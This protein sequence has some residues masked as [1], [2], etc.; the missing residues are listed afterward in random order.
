MA[1]AE[2]LL[3]R[4]LQT[5]PPSW[6]ILPPL[7]LTARFRHS[8]YVAARRLIDIALASI[9][10]ALSLPVLAAAAA[11]V[12]LT[13]RGPLFFKQLRAGK[14]G[15]PFWMYK[16]RSM[17]AGADDD[18]HLFANLNELQSSPCFKIR[19]DP[20][21]TPVGRFLRRSSID[22]L[23]QLI[24]VLCGQMTLVGPRPLPI[25]EV[26]TGTHSERK[27]LSVTPGLTCLWQISGRTEIPYCEWIA[28]D[29]FYIEN[30]SLALDLK[31]LFKTL[32]A[33]ISARGA[34]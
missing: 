27:R 5:A 3:N 10:L 30:R 12:K 14:D 25:D 1:T 4:T 21:V 8:L 7:E 26:R 2:T 33:V 22:E 15:N 6:V 32:P 19:R 18:K 28:L 9:L 34:Y 24:N 31:I 17:Y 29:L 13:S 11:A 23:P 20:R 16:L